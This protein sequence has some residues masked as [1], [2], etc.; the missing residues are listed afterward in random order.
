MRNSGNIFVLVVDRLDRSFNYWVD[1]DDLILDFLKR[2]GYP[3]SSVI[4]YENGK[5]V[6]E[7]NTRFKNGSDYK[8]EMVRAYHLPDIMDRSISQSEIHSDAIYAKTFMELTEDGG[9]INKIAFFNKHELPN[10][11]ENS[12]LQSTDSKYGIF[13]NRD[14]VVIAFSGGRDSLSLVLLMSRLRD[15]LPNID[16]TAVTVNDCID[17]LDFDYTINIC[18]EFGINHIIKEKKNIEHVFRMKIDFESALKSIYIKYG[19]QHT[20][21]TLH[22]VMRR[23]VEG[24]YDEISA[25]KLALGL[26]LEDITASILRSITTG[27]SVGYPWKRD[28]GGI[29]YIYPLWALTKKEITL[30]LKLTAESFSKQ[31]SA[32]TFDRGTVDRDIY[33]ALADHANDVWPGFSLHLFRGYENILNN[34]K[35]ERNEYLKCKNCNG[36]FT[37][38]LLNEK[39]LYNKNYCAVCS[40][41]YSIDAIL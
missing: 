35:E 40:D 33:Y 13:E 16:I 19:R 11:F 6:S 38:S 20:L 27:Y 18:D 37:H 9:G 32:A 34:M 7:F 29:N 28:F 23:M 14:K 39:E 17:K 41:L 22:Y 24:V 12:F 4:V 21:Y 26:H 3:T 31:G 10:Y 36:I 30:Y 1:E 2:E 5:I 25:N 8:I 15:K